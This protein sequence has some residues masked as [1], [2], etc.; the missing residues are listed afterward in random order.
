MKPATIAAIYARVSTEDQRCDMQLTELREYAARMGWQ[1][2]E[3]VEKASGKANAPRPVQ[4]RLFADAR[5]RKF[6]VVL[7]WKLDR[8][9]RST[10]DLLSNIQALD[11]SDIR[12]IAPGQGIDTDKR[13]PMSKLIMHIMAA[14]A[15]FERDLIVERVKAGVAEYQAAW[16]K[17]KVGKE[18]H[19]KSG[20]DLPS[21]RPKRIFRRDQVNALRKQ[22]LSWRAIAKQLSLPVSTIRP[23]S[24]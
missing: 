7:V 5:L 15:E 20:K 9:G 17:G 23:R 19:S 14:F 18:V 11:Q 4:K 22:G 1:V 3:Y 10:S 13:N 24:K 8:F 6:D 12:F 16:R 2:V 21:G